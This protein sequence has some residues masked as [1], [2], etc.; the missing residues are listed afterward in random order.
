VA[1]M[2][3]LEYLFCGLGTLGGITSFG[4][5]MLTQTDAA[6][7]PKEGPEVLL[8]FVIGILVFFGMQYIAAR[9]L[10]ETKDFGARVRRTLFLIG[11]C[12]AIAVLFFVVISF[13]MIFL[14]GPVPVVLLIAFGILA[15][16]FRPK[17]IVEE[18]IT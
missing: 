9:S 3:E 10:D 1:P 5:W 13:G 15:I 14:F 7:T 4:C 6:F 8:V 12:G 17:E 11:T 18:I 16:A 2:T